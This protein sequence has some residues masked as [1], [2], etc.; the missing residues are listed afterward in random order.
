VAKEVAERIEHRPGD[1]SGAIRWTKAWR[2]RRSAPFPSRR[3]VPSR[4]RREPRR[5]RPNRSTAAGDR[6]AGIRMDDAGAAAAGA[7]REQLSVVL[8]TFNGEAF[9]EEQ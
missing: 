2:C 6:Y 1:Y 7:R 5:A 3:T 8:A 9:L 4:R